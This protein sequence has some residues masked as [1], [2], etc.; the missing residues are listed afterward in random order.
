L[1]DATLKIKSVK[2]L[3]SNTPVKFTKQKTGITISTEGIIVEGP[4]TILV[5][6][7]S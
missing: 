5:I 1:P 3:G 6:E 2:V 7:Q 4:D